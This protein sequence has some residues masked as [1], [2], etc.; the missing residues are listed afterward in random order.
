MPEQSGVWAVREVR[1]FLFGQWIVRGA[2]RPNHFEARTIFLTSEAG[3]F[4]AMCVDTQIDYERR[5]KFTP[6]VI[7][8]ANPEVAA[9]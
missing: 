8:R 2:E 6:F 3:N 1:R 5:D 7:G 9:W 4:S